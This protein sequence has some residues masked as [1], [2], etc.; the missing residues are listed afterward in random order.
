MAE[1]RSITGTGDRLCLSQRT[2]ERHVR[3]IF[4]TV[5]LEEAGDDHRRVLAV[6]AYLRA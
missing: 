6:L 3:A 4:R 2:V 5:A 1:G